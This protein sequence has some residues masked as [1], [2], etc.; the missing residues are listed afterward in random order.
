MSKFMIQNPPKRLSTALERKRYRLYN[1]KYISSVYSFDINKMNPEI[2]HFITLWF[3]AYLVNVLSSFMALKRFTILYLT[4]KSKLNVQ[5][6]KGWHMEMLYL[7]NVFIG[8]F[9]NR[10]VN[11]KMKF[12][13]LKKLILQKIYFTNLNLR[14]WTCFL[15]WK[16][17][18]I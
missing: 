8:I 15:C 3:I 13:E 7:M 11:E 2:L 9:F 6:E 1:N 4:R 16:I 12:Y 14:W 5:C 10:C 17:N 18:L